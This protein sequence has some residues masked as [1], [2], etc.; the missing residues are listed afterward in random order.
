MQIDGRAASSPRSS[1]TLLGRVLAV[2]WW[3]ACIW[4]SVDAWLQLRP[5]IQ[6]SSVSWRHSALAL[7]QICQFG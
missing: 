1:G 3:P 2:T 6:H 5:S 7:A 4:A